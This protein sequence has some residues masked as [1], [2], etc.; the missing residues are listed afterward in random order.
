M[1]IDFLFTKIPHSK[2]FPHMMY[3]KTVKYL[4]IA[5]NQHQPTVCIRLQITH[6]ILLHSTKL[7]A[8][9]KIVYCG[10]CNWDIVIITT[11]LYH[12][13]CISMWYENLYWYESVSFKEIVGTH[14]ITTLY[15]VALFC[16]ILHMQYYC[17]ILQSGNNIEMLS[18][19]SWRPI[20]H[21]FARH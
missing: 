11:I 19:P 20:H 4:F 13:T 18:N 8:I 21:S 16:G 7:W 10:Y 5:I 2:N 9:L 15:H 6:I 3:Q 14:S 1:P 12:C 17:L